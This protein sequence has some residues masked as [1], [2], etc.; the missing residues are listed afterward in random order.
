[1]TWWDARSEHRPLVGSQSDELAHS[2]SDLILA[3]MTSDEPAF[4]DVVKKVLR[5]VQHNLRRNTDER[6]DGEKDTT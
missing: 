5:A 2:E 6:I 1:M 3:R 4:A